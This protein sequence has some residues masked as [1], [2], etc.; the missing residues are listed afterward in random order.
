[1]FAKDMSTEEKKKVWNIKNI[2]TIVAVAILLIVACI[3]YF[4]KSNNN[5]SYT[6]DGNDRLV[7]GKEISIAQS[8]YL[9][10]HFIDVGQGD[11]IFIEFPDNKNMLIDGGYAE[12]SNTV[13]NYL[14]RLS[15]SKIDLV[16]ATHSDADHIGVLPAIFEKYEVSYCFRPMIKYSGKSLLSSSFNPESRG[17]KAYEC[18]SEYYFDFLNAVRN[19]KCGWSFFNK[20]SDFSQSFVYN[21]KNCNYSFDFLTPTA[22]VSEIAYYNANDYSPICVLTYGDFSLMLTGDAEEYAEKEFLLNYADNYPDVDVLKVG[23]HG[24]STSSTEKF[25]TAVKPEYAVISCG[26]DNEYGHPH[27]ETLL[28]LAGCWIYRTDLNGTVKF[29]IPSEGKW[30]ITPPLEELL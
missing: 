20:D 10:I 13:I 14:S 9:N 25:I 17:E 6:G 4:Y 3:Y 7:F 11:C 21:G 15:V 30:R 18:D 22:K 8:D 1:M 27:D 16:L 23:H 19:E 29:E 5:V 2:F 26:K 28:N 24:S 12:K